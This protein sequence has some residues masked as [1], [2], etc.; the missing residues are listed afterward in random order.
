MNNLRLIL[1]NNW[2]QFFAFSGLIWLV[3]IHLHINR[4]LEDIIIGPHFWRKSDTYAQVM[5]YYYNGLNFF[6][7]SI[8][9]NQLTS[10][11]KAV[12][13]FPLMYLLIALQ[14]KIFGNSILLMKV[15]WIIALFGGLFSLYKIS[16]YYLKNI[17][18]SLTV[19]FILFLSS[20]FTFYAIDFLPDPFA[21]NFMFI[22]L[23]FLLNYEIKPSTTFL[24]SS[25]FFISF[26]GLIKPFFLIPFIAFICTKVILKFIVKHKSIKIHWA[27]L[28]P[29]ILVL[30]WF[31]YTLW[32]NAHIGSDYFLSSTRP[33]WGYDTSEIHRIWLRITDEW[34]FE[35][36]HENLITPL[37]LLIIVNLFWWTKGK[38]SMQI[39]YVFSVIGIL[40]FSLLFYSMFDNHDY[41]IFPILF[42]IPLALGMTLF[43]LKNIINN[44]YF[45]S[46]LGI[47]ILIFMF[48]GM[49]NSWKLNQVYR[50][51]NWISSKKEFTKY[52]NLE[53]FLQKNNVR[54]N[55]LVVTAADMSPSFAL[56]LLNRKGWSGYQ[57]KRSTISIE[58]MIDRGAEVLILNDI[59]PI[60]QADSIKVIKYLNYPID[61]TNHI[62]LY[63][64]KPY[65]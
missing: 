44:T 58:K 49:N 62:F 60:R 20:V 52:Q 11:A 10:N 18:L 16:N 7:H 21:L 25:L 37:L 1:K 46:G 8:Y 12:G 39:F 35:Y 13:E 54:Q 23:W 9:Y 3:F 56:T 40:M 63:D 17:F 51:T 27:F 38:I 47:V 32:Y 26:S 45:V 14:L 22:G 42:I 41:Y 59:K 36:F 29:F 4:H 28:I 15:N 31:Q 43:K 55:T 57:I 61:D 33:I 24:I 19:A 30:I 48:F 2:F 64:L 50:K 5:N 6:D 53:F 65:Q 34:L